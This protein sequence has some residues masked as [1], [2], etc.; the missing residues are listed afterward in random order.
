[1]IWVVLLAFAR[2]LVCVRP[3]HLDACKDE[4]EGVSAAGLAQQWGGSAA[5]RRQE[6][7]DLKESAFL[8]KVLTE[9]RSHRVLFYMAQK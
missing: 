1:M 2:E 9:R 8:L 3:T 4:I 5:Q 6:K 7:A